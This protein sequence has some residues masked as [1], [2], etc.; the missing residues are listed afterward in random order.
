MPRS[1]DAIVVGVGGVGSSALY[2]LAKK[3]LRVLGIEQF[4]IAHDRGSSHGETRAIRKAYFEHPDYVPLLH[5]AYAGWQNIEQEWGKQLLHLAGLIEIGPTDGVLIP[6]VR[7]A[8]AEH[9]IA[10]E[11][12]SPSDLRERMPGFELSEGQ[13]ALFECD[14]GY[15]LVE[16][17]VRAMATMAE[18]RGANVEWTERVN[19]WRPEGSGVAVETDKGTYFAERLV[20]ATGAWSV[21]M[22]RELGVE[23]RLLQKHLHWVEV[24]GDAYRED[25]RSPLFFYETDS[26]YYYGFPQLVDTSASA[27]YRQEACIKVAE[28]SGGQLLA[29]PAS[30]DRCVDPSEQKRVGDFLS[31]FLP[32]ASRDF[33]RHAVCMYTMS[34]D[35]HF[36]VDRH[37]QYEQVCLAAGLSGHGFKF[38]SVLGKRLADMASS[39]RDG[40]HPFP[41]LSLARFQS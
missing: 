25:R 33:T 31:Q 14:G 6:G 16:E 9:D 21:P 17:C 7:R 34:P 23:C 19:A 22:L 12:I 30:N 18:R 8:C 4:D 29:D 2:H 3:G 40:A 41:F 11:S 32:L 35:E 24:P 39:D 20:V 28:H 13:E 15:L 37:P 1:Y 10:L 5:E 38:A 36:V 27:D 26:G